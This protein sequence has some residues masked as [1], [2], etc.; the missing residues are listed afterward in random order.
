MTFDLQKFNQHTYTVMTEAI[1]QEVD[2][3]NKQSNGAVQLVAKPFSGDFDITASFKLIGD[4]VRHR[5]VNNGA[6][7]IGQKRL[8]HL[9]NVGVKIAAGTDEVVWEN[10]QYQWILQN[11]ELAAIKIGEQL[12]KGQIAN[13]LNSGV[14]AAVAAL[15]GNANVT[16]DKSTEAISYPLLTK[17]S[18]LF[19]D[20]ASALVAWVMHS[21]ALTNLQVNAL[22]NNERLFSFDNVV[23]FRDPFGRLL[24]I[25]DSGDL[26]D[27]EK[28]H[29][30]GL[31]EGGV[32][33]ANQDDFDAITTQATGKENIQ[34][35]YQAEWSYGVSVKGYAWKIA[36]GGSNPN[37][38]TLATP[39]NWEK[40]ATSDKDTAG[41]LLIAK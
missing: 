7:A 25:T 27:G 26:V 33:I 11:P 39:T 19:G 40:V 10:A 32:V 14:K 1:A 41:V 4:L 28:Y 22:A 24:V 20:K 9:K 30:L 18:G 21:G 8:T 34:R 16:L 12:A 17:A 31:T 23:V 5:D 36:D 37:A 6:N 2:V 15:K 35:T 38:A 29:V 3:F 13:M